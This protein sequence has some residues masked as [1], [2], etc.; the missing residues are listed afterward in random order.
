A[1]PPMTMPFGLEHWATNAD[2]RRLPDGLALT[3]RMFVARA[4]GMHVHARARLGTQLSAE[5][6]KYVSPLPPAGT[7]PE[8]FLT[9]VLAARR[10]REY[11][12]AV[13]QAQ[14]SDHE[15]H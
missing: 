1:L 3:A 12:V 11:A 9:A 5:F 7:H 2:M 10:E 14:K 15:S 6:E 8:T 4:P 13:K